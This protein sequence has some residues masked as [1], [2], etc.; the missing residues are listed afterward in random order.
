MLI[1]QLHIFDTSDI[2]PQNVVLYYR[3]TSCFSVSVQDRGGSP[4]LFL[5]RIET[6]EFDIF[7]ITQITYVI[8]IFKSTILTS[9]KA[10]TAHLQ[11]LNDCVYDAAPFVSQ[12]IHI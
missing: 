10:H 6:M 12:L 7:I 11:V 4:R 3:I 2:I 8:I 9:S 1:S 5:T